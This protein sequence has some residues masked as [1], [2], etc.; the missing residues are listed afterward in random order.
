M[1]RA[2]LSVVIPLVDA[3]GDIARHVRSWT[4]GQTLPRERFQ[5]ILASAKVAH[6]FFVAADADGKVVEST[7]AITRVY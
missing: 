5:V 6:S 2:K 3:R 7:P 4:A 1:G